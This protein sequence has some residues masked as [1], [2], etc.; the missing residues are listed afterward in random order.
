M[1]GG[2]HPSEAVHSILSMWSVV[3]VSYAVWIQGWEV[4]Y[5]PVNVRPNTSSF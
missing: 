2:S 5:V 4:L 3:A 1:R